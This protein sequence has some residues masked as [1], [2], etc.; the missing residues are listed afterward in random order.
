MKDRLLACFSP[1]R[2]NFITLIIQN[3]NFFKI[4]SIGNIRII[5]MKTT[6]FFLC[7]QA[8][9]PEKRKLKARRFLSH[10]FPEWISGSKLRELVT[11]IIE[12][13]LWGYGG[14]LAMS[15]LWINT[16]SPSLFTCFALFIDLLLAKFVK[17]LFESKKPFVGI[18]SFFRDNR[19]FFVIIQLFS[20]SKD[21][22]LYSL[23]FFDII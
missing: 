23:S 3:W 13:W 4:L 16:F 7:R 1:M 11:R 9:L 18:V 8:L 21:I 17:T 5:L 14:L 19:L 12:G 20:G 10:S 6:N 2:V 22:N 15:F